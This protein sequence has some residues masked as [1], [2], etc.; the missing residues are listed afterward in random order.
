MLLNLIAFQIGWFACVLGG[1]RGWPWLGVLVTATAIILHLYQAARPRTEAMLIGLS[2]LLGFVADSLLT[3]MGL[4]RFPSGQFHPDLAP[5]WMVA[6]WMLFATTFNVALGWLKPRLGLAALLG[7]IAGPLAYYG[8][9]QLGGVSFE[10][11]AASLLAV[12]GVWTL[13]MPLLLVI[14]NRWNGMAETIPTS[15]EPGTSGKAGKPG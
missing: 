10:N 6:M 14:A 7:M 1:A 3:G 9:A 11:P 8:G 5:Y 13:A 2:G 4:L 12:A 15:A